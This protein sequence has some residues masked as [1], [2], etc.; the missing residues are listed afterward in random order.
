MKLELFTLLKSCNNETNKNNKME[1]K[2]ITEGN[3]LIAEFMG[4]THPYKCDIWRFEEFFIS[5]PCNN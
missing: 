3:K 1:A 5:L 4:Y 2:Q